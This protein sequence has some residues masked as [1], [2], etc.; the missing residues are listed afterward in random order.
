MKRK[1]AIGERTINWKLLTY[2]EEKSVRGVT[3]LRREGREVLL[4]PD[5]IIF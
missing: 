2:Y 1:K 3:K 4:L 5:W